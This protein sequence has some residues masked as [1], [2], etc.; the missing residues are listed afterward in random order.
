VTAGIEATE[1]LANKPARFLEDLRVQYLPSY[2]AE[3][4]W[5]IPWNGSGACVA[6]A[7]PLPWCVHRLAPLARHFALLSRWGL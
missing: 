1:G 6:P 3:V 7:G 5:G 2:F 4:E